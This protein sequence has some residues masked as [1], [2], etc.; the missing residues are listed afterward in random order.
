MEQNKFSAY[1]EIGADFTAGMNVIIADLPTT[2]TIEEIEK[3]I[4]SYVESIY[5]PRT[6]IT[7]EKQK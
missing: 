6:I 4:D 7:P 3:M 2:H 5:Y 1:L